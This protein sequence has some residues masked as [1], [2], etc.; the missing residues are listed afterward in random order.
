MIVLLNNIS[1]NRLKLKVKQVVNK[2]L[3]S[4]NI[5]CF[6]CIQCGETDEEIAEKYC[7]NIG[8]KYRL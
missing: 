5:V 3:R 8:C 7:G 2:K 1:T 6:K 4:T